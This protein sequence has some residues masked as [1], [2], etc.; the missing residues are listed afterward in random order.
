MLFCLG[1]LIE[2]SI[3]SRRFRFAEILALS[4]RVNGKVVYFFLNAVAQ[5]FEIERNFVGKKIVIEVGWERIITING[6]GKGGRITGMGRV[7]GKMKVSWYRMICTKRRR[8]K[9]I[10]RMR[11][12][13]IRKIVWI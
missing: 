3:V 4:F 6:R 10:I 9:D 1:R 7:L 12:I 8:M 13:I 2:I 5:F 11:G